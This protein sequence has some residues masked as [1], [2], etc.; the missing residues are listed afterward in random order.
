MRFFKTVILNVRRS[1]SVNVDFHLLFLFADDVFPWFMHAD[2][3]S[4]TSLDTPNN[5]AAFARD[6]T[7]KRATTICPLL[8]R[9]VSH[10]SILSHG[11]S[12]NTISN[13]P[14]RALQNIRNGRRLFSVVNWSSFNVDKRN[15]FY[16]S[17]SQCFHYVWTICMLC[18]K[19][20]R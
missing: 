7:A 2:I 17:I 13:A 19:N 9:T 10:F 14:T 3:T 15:K 8:N 6:T 20:N 5:V 11:L 4:D 18:P 12:Q 1:L 16:S